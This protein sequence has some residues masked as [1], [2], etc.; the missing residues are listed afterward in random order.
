VDGQGRTPL[1]FVLTA[2]LADYLADAIDADLQPGER[3]DLGWDRPTS[4]AE[5]AELLSRAADR[6]IEVRA[7]P[8][9][10]TRAVGA[11]VGPFV[12]SMKDTASM[13]R[14]FDTGEYVAGTAR[15]TEVFGQPPTAEDVIKRLA[16]QLHAN[17]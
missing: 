10:V 6:T 17:G 1:T 13:F 9:L 15:Q 14:W 7:I 4:I 8:P 16:E 5:V 12:P 3:I 2:D 11:L